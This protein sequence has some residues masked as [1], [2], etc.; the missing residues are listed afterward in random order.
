MNFKLDNQILEMDISLIRGGLEII[1]SNRDDIELTF[2]ELRK[3]TAD[4]LFDISFQE[5]LLMIRERTW[6][7]TAMPSS[8]FRNGANHDLILTIPTGIKLKGAISTVSGD[9][10]A[11]NLNGPLQIKTISGQM[12]FG[13]I[14]SSRL[15][16]QNIGGNL[17]IDNMI[18]AVNAKV[19]SGKCMINNGQIKRFNF[20]SVSGDITVNADFDLDR[21]SSVQTVSGDTAL[22][23]LSYAGDGVINISTLSGETA[24]K[25]DLP[26]EK[27]EI[28]K[29]MPFLKN[30]P[31]KTVIPAMKNF[32]S[33][34]TR[35]GDDDEVE[36][37]ATEHSEN[38]EQYINQ[39]LQMLSD[40]KISAEE[41]ERL[42][43]ALK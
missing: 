4:E 15:R 3:N 30:H 24:I 32:V 7:K 11:D 43:N 38:N 19:V 41:A 25:G 42:I 10:Q 2:S 22:N 8:F 13:R 26:E 27:L 18:G 5:D 9:I 21:D 28:K 14:E 29:R 35:A 16:L 40:G 23:I 12:T 17:T 36:I 31:F 6:K 1:E 20:S 39:I 34:F 37:H 33:S